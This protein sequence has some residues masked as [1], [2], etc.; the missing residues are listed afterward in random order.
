M[1]KMDTHFYGGNGIVGAQVPLGTG[2]AFAQKYNKTG[3]VT[4]NYFCD[5]AANQ[6]QV[7]D[8]FNLAKVW[9]LPVVFVVENNQYAMGTSVERASA[10][11]NFYTRGHYIPGIEV[12]IFTTVNFSVME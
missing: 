4:Y 3:R 11:R 7:Y 8:A 9:D 6:G 1:Y 5:G 2:I 10:T 12:R